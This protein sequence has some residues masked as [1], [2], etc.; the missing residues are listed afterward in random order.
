MKLGALTGCH[1]MN[2]RSFS[3][4]G[5]QF[6]LCARCTGLLAGQIA[7]LASFMVYIRLDIRLLLFFAAASV[8]PL[9][10]D[11]LGQLKKFWVSNNPRRLLTGILC[12]YFVTLFNINLIIRLIKFVKSL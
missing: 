8:L 10:I 6:P 9:G 4:G 11:G 5:C 3:F 1:Q 12:G 7:A 2:E